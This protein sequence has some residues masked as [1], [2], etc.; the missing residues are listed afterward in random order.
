MS[1]RKYRQKGYQDSGSSG[2]SDDRPR[3]P[4]PAYNR[5]SPDKPRGR[6]LGAPKD[7]VFRCHACGEKQPLDREIGVDETCS[8]CG[9]ALHACVQ[10][11]YFDTSARFECRQTLTEPVRSKTKPI[12]CELF[13]PKIAREFGADSGSQTDARSAFDALFKI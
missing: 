4:K 3:P 8:R 7:S 2:R 11:T 5:L 13:S 1:D 6:G 12:H 9:A 10:C